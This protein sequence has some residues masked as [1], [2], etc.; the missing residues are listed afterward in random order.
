[1]L[2]SKVE[3]VILRPGSFFG[4]G[5][6]LNFGRMAQRM[7]DGKGVI[8]GRGDNHLPFCYIT[9]IV[10]GFMLAAY[11]V[12]APGNVYNITN[13]HPLTQLEMFNEIADAVDGIRPTRHLPYLPIY[14]GSIVAEKVVAPVTRREPFVTTHGALM[15][16]S[17][18]KHSIEKARRE[19]GFEPKV[20][21]R[22]GIRLAAEWFNAGGMNEVAAT[23]ASQHAPLA[24][25]MK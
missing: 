7:K 16:G 8:I 5:D 9:D 25:A 12:N 13:D 3:T 18:N 17:D 23:S 1:M 15:F 2:N 21:M 14:Y 11:H 6:R 4:P 10:Q 24:G 19:L 20:D 22:T